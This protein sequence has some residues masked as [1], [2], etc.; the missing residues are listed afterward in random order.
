MDKIEVEIIDAVGKDESPKV[1]KCVDE[2]SNTL[3]K[4][5]QESFDGFGQELIDILLS[6]Q[7][8]DD[9]TSEAPSEKDIQTL[10]KKIWNLQSMKTKMKE[11]ET[12]LRDE[13]EA[14]K[15]I[16]SKIQPL[17][18]AFT[19]GKIKEVVQES[20]AYQKISTQ[21]VEAIKLKM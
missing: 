21:L 17:Q 12:K 5:I 20:K 19:A 16:S 9:E 11:Q 4:S 10:R 2:L 7:N 13:I 6:S 18:D 1:V 14:A 3:Q 15:K 8:I